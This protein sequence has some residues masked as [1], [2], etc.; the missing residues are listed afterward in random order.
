MRSQMLDKPWTSSD[1]VPY[2]KFI[3]IARTIFVIIVI[4][5]KT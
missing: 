3:F 5:G 2:L 1:Y 4:V